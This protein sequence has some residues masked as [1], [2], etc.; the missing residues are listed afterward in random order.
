M[1]IGI[2]MP[3]QVRDVDPTV[4]P[5]WAKRAEA[6]GFSALGTI[7]RIAYPG[8]RANVLDYYAGMGEY[9]DMAAAHLSHDAES[10]RATVALSGHWAST[11]SCRPPTM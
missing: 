4:I 10:A 6:A 3:D 11:C 1:K 7:G 5:E 2:G 8:G 9:A